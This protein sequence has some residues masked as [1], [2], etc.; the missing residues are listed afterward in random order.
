MWEE[1]CDYGEDIDRLTRCIT[2]YINFYMENT[3]H[4]DCL[5]FLQQQTWDQPWYEG[6]T[7]GE[8]EVF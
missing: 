6:S 5:V 8:K 2:D 3:T 7:E 4:Q 1:L